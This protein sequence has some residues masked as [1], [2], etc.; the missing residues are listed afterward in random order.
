MPTPANY[1]KALPSRRRRTP[2]TPSSPPTSETWPGSGASD[3]LARVRLRLPARRHRRLLRTGVPMTTTESD[4]QTSWTEW[5]AHAGAGSPHSAR[6]AQSHRVALARWRGPRLRRPARHLAGRRRRRRAHRRG[7]RR[8]RRGR[9][10]RIRHRPAAARATACRGSLSASA[11][12]R[13]E[14]IRRTD[15]YALRVRDPEAITRT[16]F[17]GA[18]AFPVAEKRIVTGR[19]MPYAEP[20]RIVVGAV[21]DGLN[22]YPTAVGTVRF[23]LDGEAHE[24]VALP[25]KPGGSTLHF[26][27]LTSAR[28]PTGAGVSSG[29]TTP[30]RTARSRSTS[31]GRSTCPARSPR[32]QPARCRPRTTSSPSPWPPENRT[33]LRARPRGPDVLTTRHPG[34]PG[35]RYVGRAGAVS[36]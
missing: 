9:P 30:S 18:P 5:H 6:L 15:S 32:S 7:L 10:T 19:F 24:L 2:C 11:T 35:R 29:S 33:P 23:E 17:T 26:R 27:D 34:R 14:V 20:R 25:G 3:T 1:D 4:L 22:H 8:H 36:E 21:V 13:V 12:R 28:T 31:T 16:A